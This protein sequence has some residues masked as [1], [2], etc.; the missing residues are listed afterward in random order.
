MTELQL[1]GLGALLGLQHATEADHLAAVAT[2]A[3]RQH[4]LAQ[5]MKQGAAWG[6][7]HGLVLLAVGGVALALG[8]TLPQPLAHGL[9]M[10]VGVMLLLLGADT[11][12]RAGARSAQVHS[13]G[14]DH[15]HGQGHG[16]TSG[17][18]P[19]PPWRA[20]TVGMVHGLA[21]SAAL[22]LLSLGAVHSWPLG[23]AYIAL[24]GAGSMAGMAA[25]SLAIAVPLHLSARRLAGLHRALTGLLGLVSCVIGAATL[26]G[27]RG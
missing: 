11:L 18:A 4:T 9:E 8:R 23:L 1:L 16:H 24:F 3:A 12:R 14:H 27:A 6:L 22:V 19:R 2:L 26:L 21:G 7:G 13:H 17:T 15:A 20:L 5:G 10:A 25:L